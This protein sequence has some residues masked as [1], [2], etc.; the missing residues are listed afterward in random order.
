LFYIVSCHGDTSDGRAHFGPFW[1]IFWVFLTL[2]NAT[3]SRGGG[4]FN[5]VTLQPKRGIM[6][7]YNVFPHSIRKVSVW[8]DAEE[9]S[10][11]LQEAV[12]FRERCHGRLF[13]ARITRKSKKMAQN[14]ILHRSYLHGT[15]QYK[16]I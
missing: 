3:T 6:Y 7:V 14:E 10:S 11:S 12:P 4:K 16:T 5:S 9:S 1:A 15:G 2:H 8:S 13:T